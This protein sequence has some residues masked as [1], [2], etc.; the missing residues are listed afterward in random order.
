MHLIQ[1]NGYNCLLPS[2]DHHITKISRLLQFQSPSIIED[3]RRISQCLLIQNNRCDCLLPS[4]DHHLAKISSL[5]QFQSPW[6]IEDERRI[7]Q[8]LLIQNNRCDCLLPSSDHHL[9]KISRLYCSF[10]TEDCWNYASLFRYWYYFCLINWQIRRWAHERTTAFAF[11]VTKTASSNFLNYHPQLCETK[12]C[13]LYGS[14]Y[15]GDKTN[16]ENLSGI[17]DKIFSQD[18]PVG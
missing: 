10:R 6:I 15:N 14:H 8:C 7:S 3:E 1:N 5:L 9:A 18:Q 17:R 4:S 16:E 2:S 13:Q 11:D 12:F